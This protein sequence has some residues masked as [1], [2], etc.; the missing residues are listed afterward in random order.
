MR[1]FEKGN[2]KRGKAARRLFA[3]A[4]VLLLLLAGGCGD[5]N[6]KPRIGETPHLEEARKFGREL[7]L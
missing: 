2:R 6:G 4:A 7:Y 1:D 3:G 5:T